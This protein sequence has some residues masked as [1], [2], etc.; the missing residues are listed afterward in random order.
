MKKFSAKNSASKSFVCTVAKTATTNDLQLACVEKVNPRKHTKAQCPVSSDIL[1][2]QPTLDNLC[3]TVTCDATVNIQSINIERVLVE[4]EQTL[5]LPFDAVPTLNPPADVTCPITP[6][7]SDPLVSGV[8]NQNVSLPLEWLIL[9]NNSSH[10]PLLPR[11]RSAGPWYFEKEPFSTSNRTVL[12]AGCR[13][14]FDPTSTRDDDRFPPFAP[15]AG[16]ETRSII[17]LTFDASILDPRTAKVA[18]DID[19]GY[20]SELNFDFFTIYVDEVIVFQDARPGASEEDP[21]AKGH[22]DLVVDVNAV[23]RFEYYRDG[24]TYGGVDSVYFVINKASPIFDLAFPTTLILRRGDLIL[25]DYRTL[26]ELDGTE[27][28]APIDCSI[29]LR[30]GDQL[31]LEADPVVYAEYNVTASYQNI[32]QIHDHRY[33]ETF[34]A[35]VEFNVIKYNKREPKSLA[36]IGG[37][38]NTDGFFDRTLVFIEEI[39]GCPTRGPATIRVKTYSLASSGPYYVN[40]YWFAFFLTMTEIARNVYQDS[41]SGLIY[42]FDPLTGELRLDVSDLNNLPGPNS[43]AATVFKPIRNPDERYWQYELDLTDPD[44][45]FNTPTNFFDFVGQYY[46]SGFLSSQFGVR[47]IS[48]WPQINP[49]QLDETQVR[50]SYGTVTKAEYDDLF[51]RLKDIGFERKYRI[52]RWV[53]WPYPSKGNG[54]L[55][56]HPKL[57]ASQKQKLRW[58]INQNRYDYLAFV[59]YLADEGERNYPKLCPG[60]TVK[61]C[62]T[63]TRLD[64]FP[65]RLAMDGYHTG[66]KPGP[67]FMQTYSGIDPRNGQPIPSDRSFNIFKEWAY[68]TIRLPITIDS[69]NNTI[70]SRGGGI[71]RYGDAPFF[72]TAIITASGNPPLGPYDVVSTTRGQNLFLNPLNGNIV[73]PEPLNASTPFTNPEEIA[74]N[75]IIIVIE[76]GVSPGS[77]TMIARA[78][79]AGAIGVILIDPR[80]PDG[81][82]FPGYGGAGA[83]PSVFM[84]FDSGMEI[85]NALQN[86]RTISI[87]VQ[88]DS[89]IHKTILPSGTFYLTDLLQQLFDAYVAGTSEFYIEL[90]NFIAG[91]YGWN[92]I[93]ALGGTVQALLF[94]PDDATYASNFFGPKGLDIAYLWGDTPNTPLVNQVQFLSNDFYDGTYAQLQ[95]GQYKT[96]T[97]LTSAEAKA[98]I[99][100]LDCDFNLSVDDEGCG[101]HNNKTKSASKQSPS[102]K[103]STK[104]ASKC[105]TVTAKRGPI[106]YDTT[107]EK[108]VAAILELSMAKSTELHSVIT[109]WVYKSTHGLYELPIDMREFLE[110]LKHVVLDPAVTYRAPFNDVDGL[111]LE[112]PPSPVPGVPIAALW[113]PYVYSAIIFMSSNHGG[114]GSEMYKADA[115]RKTTEGQTAFDTKLDWIIPRPQ[116]T[117]FYKTPTI[118]PIVEGV[119]IGDISGRKVEI[120]IVNYLEDPQWLGYTTIAEGTYAGAPDYYFI[121]YREHTGSDFLE[122]EPWDI[123]NPNAVA[124]GCIVGIIKDSKVRSILGLSAGVESPRYGYITWYRSAWS[125]EGDNALLPWYDPEFTTVDASAAMAAARV[126]QYFNENNVKHIIIDVRSTVGGG[127]PFW[128]AFASLVGGDR[129]F[130]LTD[131]TPV[132][133]LEPNGTQSVRTTDNFQV[134]REEA[135][136]VEYNFRDSIFEASPSAFIEGGILDLVPGGIWNGEVTGQAALGET[137]NLIWMYSSYSL[138]SPQ[139]SLLSVKGTSLNKTTYDGDFGKSTQFIQYGS[140]YIPFSTAGNF[141]SYINWWTTGRAGQEENPV[142]LMFGIDRWESFRYGYI[143]GS[144][145]LIGGVLKATD[146]EFSALHEPHIKWDMNMVV[147]FQDIGYTVGNPGVIPAVD[148]EPWVPARYPDV[149]F[150]QPLTYRDSTLERAVQMAYDPELVSHFHKEDGYGYVTQP[151]A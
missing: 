73:L 80:F 21:Y 23:V 89:P 29:D 26:I 110:R 100:S 20:S 34:R 151:P 82:I 47:S 51:R 67:E 84:G 76:P 124:G 52:Q 102:A 28:L 94:G 87:E 4:P 117:V 50:A 64:G 56:V 139:I 144:D 19:F 32:P 48:T 111:I 25:K 93:F 3:A 55:V 31:C 131:I 44:R 140:Y 38:Y 36:F 104:V 9:T 63:G 65:L 53:Y 14:T 113:A 130:N 77:G 127:N 123:V 79:A 18:L 16:Q 143:D 35:P 24:N 58:V 7:S 138:S 69:S 8:I 119:G 103:C 125:S 85:V 129:L 6:S 83:L 70:Y 71:S 145:D 66:P 17:D 37:W 45:E 132:V 150:G 92:D 137:S 147:F 41:G 46:K 5:I 30:K 43:T 42:I 126:L 57:T 62:G 133:T 90:G 101:D 88:L 146:Q 75:I 22:V 68:Y 106:T 120:P 10:P 136:L 135:G 108:F 2:L 109:P 39:S 86:G 12:T 105:P 114:D 141:T 118:L 1:V 149:V 33:E 54:N 59:P 134:A 121:P 97:P 27:N 128:S 148:G 122:P 11:E 13:E 40:D 96:H 61:L 72:L 99:D 107:Y 78:I 95:P 49:L 112:T 116:E 81:T 142:G 60:E 15:G 74:G 98:L 115:W 91:Y